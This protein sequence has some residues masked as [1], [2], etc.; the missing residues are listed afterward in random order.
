MEPYLIWLVAGLALVIAELA[1]GTFYL[2]VI[3]VGAFAGGAMAWGGQS[4]WLS[5]V[6]ASAVAAAGVVAVSRYHAPRAA[7]AVN[8]LD[9]GQTAVFERW[10]SAEDRLARVRYRNASW[11]ARVLDDAALAEGRIVHIRSVAGSTLQVS[12]AAD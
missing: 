10:V 6:V 1:S 2:L 3:A 11:D 9:V 8:A 4:F 12:S 5:A 7:R